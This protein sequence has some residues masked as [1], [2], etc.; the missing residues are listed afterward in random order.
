[1]KV[2][3]YPK[4]LPEIYGTVIFLGLVAY[5][6]L[7]QLL[8][9]LEVMELRLLNV[10]IFIAGVYY[11]LRQYKRTHEVEITYFK[12]LQIG[13]AA[14]FIGIS[15]F[16]LFLFLFIKLQP[17]FLEKVDDPIMGKDID[18]FIATFSVWLQGTFAGLFAT[19]LV[20]HTTRTRRE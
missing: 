3:E 9:L 7:I 5:L 8:G 11:A 20:V 4:R 2:F 12:A 6:F 10:F 14:S 15:T 19:F 1:M 18:V 16:T 13:I 17:E